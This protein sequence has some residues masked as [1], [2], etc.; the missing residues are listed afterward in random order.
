MKEDATDKKFGELMRMNVKG[1][2]PHKTKKHG[3]V[4]VW[5]IRSRTEIAIHTDQ[6]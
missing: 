5:R 3:H 2:T 1:A 6:Q 4:T